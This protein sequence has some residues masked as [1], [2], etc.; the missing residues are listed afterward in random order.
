MLPKNWY[1]RAKHFYEE[2]TRVKKGIAAWK[3]GDLDTFGKLIFESGYSS[4]YNY[5]A[6]S[7]ELKE[8]YNIMLETDGIYGGRFSGAGFKGCCLA[9]I[10][11]EKQED[12][13]RTVE[14]K[15]LKA[16]KYLFALFISLFIRQMGPVFFVFHKK[17]VHEKTGTR[18][19]VLWSETWNF[20]RLPILWLRSSRTASTSATSSPWLAQSTIT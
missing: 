11:P 5:E 10:D 13:L 4:I 19:Q 15:Y 14:Q 17:S 20:F 6:G 7:E 1:K 16:L 9:V 8:I 12:I 18:D 3:N 2:N